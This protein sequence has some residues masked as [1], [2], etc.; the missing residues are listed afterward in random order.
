M[1][2]N[3]RNIYHKNL[4]NKFYVVKNHYKLIKGFI[5]SKVKTK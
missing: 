4:L 2:T 5:K 1:Q 3:E